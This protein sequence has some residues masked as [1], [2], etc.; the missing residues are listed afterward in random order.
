MFKN[1][2]ASVS[3][4]ANIDLSLPPFAPETDARIPPIYIESLD[5]F[6]VLKRLDPSK[7]KGLLN[8]PNRLLRLCCET[9][10]TPFS[11]LFNFIIWIAQY[12][13]AWKFATVVPIHKKGSYPDVANYRP[14]AVLPSLFKTFER[15]IHR[16]IYS[17]LESNKLLCESN[18]GFRE[19]RSTVTSLL[20]TAHKLYTACDRDLSSRI[21][22]V[23]ISKAFD[24]II[25]SGLIYK[26]E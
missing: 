11:L 23:D 8:L 25:H 13:S 6:H 4:L 7:S 17:Y 10:N 16:H 14:I 18:S 3:T 19:K 24:R 1:F 15:I 12:S 2:F 9:L 26:L 5:I 20:E 22:Y 21:V